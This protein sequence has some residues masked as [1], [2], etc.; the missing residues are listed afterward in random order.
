[1]G[2]EVI[3][4]EKKDRPCIS[5][6]QRNEVTGVP[7][8]INDCPAYKDV[9][10][11]KF[12]V[13]LDLGNPKAIV[14]A[15]RL[16]ATADVVVDGFKPGVI[17]KLGLGYD[18]LKEIK[19]DIIMLSTSANGGIGPESQFSGYAPMFNATGSLG[20]MT[21]YPDG[22]PT[23]MRLSIDNLVAHLNAFA[24][25]AALIHKKETGEGQY[26]DTSSQEGIAC[27]VGDSVMDYTMNGRVQT[28]NGNS[29]DAMAPHN[30]FHC[31]GEDKWISIAVA[32][33]EEWRALCQTMGN[34]AWCRELRFA[35]AYSRWYHQEELDK[36]MESWA[37]EQNNFDL[38]HQ[39][40]QKGV[41]AVPS[42]TSEDLFTNEHLAEREF[43]QLIDRPIGKYMIVS[44]P[45]R[46]S[47]T[48]A[49]FVRD[50]PALGEH[51]DYVFGELLGH[52]KEELAAFEAEGVFS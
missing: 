33:D 10:M 37:V 2:A 43:S 14:L 17:K 45:W 39:L 24:I 47:E 19:P 27:L 51:N 15:K 49:G 16:V 46:L 28:R 4:V 31:I 22:P 23:V 12:G 25:M 48:P 7:Y 29:D 21:G 50:A 3:K 11:N 36:L 52:S 20:D 41:A 44:P 5:R 8:D 9:N 34:P 40:Q 26:I 13:T 42:Y 1:M 30:C 32:T 6:R 35:D 18:T 38:M